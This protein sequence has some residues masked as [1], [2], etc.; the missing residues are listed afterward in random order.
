MRRRPQF[1]RRLIAASAALLFLAGCTENGEGTENEA[2]ATSPEP[3]PTAIPTPS[4][5]P[6]GPDEGD[7]SEAEATPV[8]DEPEP[9]LHLVGDD[10]DQIV[11]SH[12][13]FTT[14]LLRHPDP[15][16]FDEITHPDCECYVQKEL[17]AH[18]EREGLRW[19]GGDDGIKV[20]QVTIVDDQARNLVHL[21]VVFERPDGG[22]L[23]DAHGEVHDQVEPR[24]PWVEDLIFVR[25]HNAAPWKLRD[26][27]DRGPA[28]ESLRDE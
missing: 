5:A 1:R 20:R 2:A 14:W 26:F 24:E 4:P 19:T 28:D 3:S 21:Q 25:E 27:L 16:R 13:A 17:L 11:R 9:E 7:D 8:V 23:I 10:Y 15:K 6:T 22:Q 12:T 18:Y